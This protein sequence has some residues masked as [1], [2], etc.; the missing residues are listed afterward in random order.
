[1]QKHHL[2]VSFLFLVI[3]LRITRLNVISVLYGSNHRIGFVI[4][5][6]ECSLKDTCVHIM[7]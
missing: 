5:F 7:N 4:Y 3:C 1:M 2:I 6:M